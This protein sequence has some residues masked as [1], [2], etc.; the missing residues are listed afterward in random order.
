MRPDRCHTAARLRRLGRSPKGFLLRY[1]GA[2]TVIALPGEPAARVGLAILTASAAAITLD[3]AFERLRS[4]RWIVPDGAAITALLC[5]LILAPQSAWYLPPAAG[6]IAIASKHLIR[7]RWGK[8]RI[9]VLNPAAAGLFATLLVFP[10][11]QSWWG[12]LTGR[13]TIWILALIAIGITVDRHV[14]KLPQA[15]AFLATY[16]G[17]FTTIAVTTIGGGVLSISQRLAEVYRPPFL[18]AALFFGFFMLTDPPTS[19]NRDD[20]QVRFGALAG[21]IAVVA[22]LTIHTLAFPLA[23][24]LAANLALAWHRRRAV[25]APALACPAQAAADDP[26]LNQP[27]APAPGR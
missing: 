16:Y 12:A 15:L 20:E 27:T 13:P 3:V 22:Y 23:G 24:L 19:P 8:R 4:R 10:A 17:L 21:T 25:H 18:D 9:H 11:G 26:S 1:L 6:A 7:V 2:L 14:A 5:A